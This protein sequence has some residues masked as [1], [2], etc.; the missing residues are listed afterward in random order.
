MCVLAVAVSL[1]FVCLLTLAVGSSSA[2]ALRGRDAHH[3]T[4]SGRPWAIAWRCFVEL[5]SVFSPSIFDAANMK[6]CRARSCMGCA[7]G[8]AAAANRP[9]GSQGADIHANSRHK[10]PDPKRR[11]VSSAPR[12]T[13][14]GS[15]HSRASPP[16]PF[17]TRQRGH[18]HQRMPQTSDGH[19]LPMA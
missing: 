2:E 8:Q 1:A 3:V 16:R 13:E 12:L 17:A 15:Q 14:E 18:P 10:L 19:G 6:H 11:P 9:P 4:G 7:W 5:A